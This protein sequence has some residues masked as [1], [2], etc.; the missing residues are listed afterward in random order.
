MHESYAYKAPHIFTKY[1]YRAKALFSSY[2][3]IDLNGLAWLQSVLYQD[4]DLLVSFNIFCLTHPLVS[5]NGLLHIKAQD[6]E[7]LSQR[8]A[9]IVENQSP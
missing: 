6:L 4:K 5:G 7:D 2:G 3:D 1:F 9:V 8:Y